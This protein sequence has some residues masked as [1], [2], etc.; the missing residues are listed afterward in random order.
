MK[1]RTS[2][3]VRGE[4]G[5]NGGGVMG[6]PGQRQPRKREDQESAM[7][8]NRKQVEELTSWNML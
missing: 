3:L 7:R 1:N 8:E 2:K 5:D 4:E 6:V